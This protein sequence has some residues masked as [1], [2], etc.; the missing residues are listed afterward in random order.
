MG[1]GLGRPTRSPSSPA[2][3]V[4]EVTG[5]AGFARADGDGSN[6]CDASCPRVAD[7]SW[8]ACPVAGGIDQAVAAASLLPS[9]VSRLAR[10]HPATLATIVAAG[11]T[12]EK[13][14]RPARRACEARRAVRTG[15][16]AQAQAGPARRR[17]GRTAACDAVHSARTATGAMAPW[18]VAREHPSGTQP[19][20]SRRGPAKRAGL[21]GLAPCGLG[22]GPP[23]LAAPTPLLGVHSRMW[24]ERPGPP[25]RGRPTARGSGRNCRAVSQPISLLP[26]ATV[27]FPNG[28]T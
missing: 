20:V 7:G 17:R 9:S 10:R 14:S 28:L 16:A 3:P 15:V 22:L 24:G 2:N 25:P 19:M 13:E 6:G 27:I 5:Y 23:E 21:G 1:A 8:R 18:R 12:C 11:S 26:T 4:L